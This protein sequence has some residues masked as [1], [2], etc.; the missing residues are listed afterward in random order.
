MPHWEIWA[1][2]ETWKCTCIQ[3]T[4]HRRHCICGLKKTHTFLEWP[5][6]LITRCFWINVTVSNSFL[7]SF[8]FCFF[9]SQLSAQLA[10]S[11]ESSVKFP[12]SPREGVAA[13]GGPEENKTVDELWEIIRLEDTF[14]LLCTFCWPLG[15]VIVIIF[16]IVIGETGWN[17]NT[18]GHKWETRISNVNNHITN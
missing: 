3:R 14:C 7:F 8:C 17:T 15:E 1:A 12:P 13:E 11:K 18:F 2:E 10:A 16:I 4:F 6:P 9:Y 5:S